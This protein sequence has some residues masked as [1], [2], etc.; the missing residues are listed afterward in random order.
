[1]TAEEA[2]ADPTVEIL[3]ID[4]ED[5]AFILGKGG[6]TKKKVAR[7]AGV[8]LELDSSAMDAAA[9]NNA[10]GGDAGANSAPSPSHALYIKDKSEAKRRRAREYVGFVLQQRRGKIEV[11]FPSDGKPR[12]DLSIVEVPDDG[13]KAYITGKNGS[14]LRMMEEEWGTLMFFGRARDAKGELGEDALMV[15]GTR[16]ARRGAELKVMSA[17]E[18]KVPGTFVDAATKTL[19]EKLSQPGDDENDGFRYDVFPFER[20]EISYALGAQGS[21]RKKLAAA[22]GAMLEYIGPLAV[23]AGTSGERKRCWDYLNWLLKQKNDPRLQIDPDG[24]DDVSIMPIPSG[25]APRL[26]GSKGE[27]IRSIERET[28]TFIVV[29]DV[30]GGARGDERLLVF[31]GEEVRSI[32]WSPYDRDRVV[33]ADP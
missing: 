9:A 29:N 10:N 2:A 31:G 4:P 3:S 21:T 11:D 32:H 12:D 22:S 26:Q 16:R 5:A 1:M 19:R 6:N 24:R 30:P 18:H 17:V 20:D 27:N 33:N 13:C 28:S 7:A 14:V 23:M 8:K 25:K 15:L